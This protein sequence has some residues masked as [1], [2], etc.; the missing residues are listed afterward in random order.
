MVLP[1][2]ELHTGQS[3]TDPPL[4]TVVTPFHNTADYLEQCIKSVLAQ[5]Y[6]HFEYLL[7]DNCSSDGSTEIA[8]ALAQSDSRVRY[9]RFDELIPQVPN[10]NRALEQM[11]V[12]AQWCKIVQADDWIHERCLERMVEVGNLDERIGIV[13]SYYLKGNEVRGY[14]LPTEQRVFDGRSA[15]RYQLRQKFYFMGSPTTLLYRASVVRSRRPFYALERF[16]EDTDAAYEILEQSRLGFVHEILSVL[17]VD[18]PSITASLETFNPGILNT[19]VVLERYGDR[20][21]PPSESQFRKRVAKVKYFLF[22]GQS[23][24]KVRP[25]AFWD[26]HK[27]EVN[28]M[29]RRWSWTSVF[30]WSFVAA[31]TLLLNPLS[32]TTDILR[33][34]RDKTLGQ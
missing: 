20:F 17:R 30:A 7:C 29:G 24:L 12:S 10:Y 13:A 5:T 2:H 34:L 26:Y 21:L 31:L 23:A 11:S 25:K 28:A 4:V 3:A 16:H 15:C 6:E 1:K 32:T 8:R 22:L 18:N 14:G 33:R 27:S 9:I 19:W